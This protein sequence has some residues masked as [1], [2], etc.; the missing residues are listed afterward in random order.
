M[1]AIEEK[2]KPDQRTDPAFAEDGIDI[3]LSDVFGINL[4]QPLER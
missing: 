1:A 4:R 3:P 2:Q